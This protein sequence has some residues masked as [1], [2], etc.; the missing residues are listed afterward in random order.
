M[1]MPLTVLSRLWL[2]LTLSEIYQKY[3]ISAKEAQQVL[4]VL[5]PEV[6]V[7]KMDGHTKEAA[8]SST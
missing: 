7:T 3:K 4:N 1:Y 8:P 2:D 6:K 5:Y